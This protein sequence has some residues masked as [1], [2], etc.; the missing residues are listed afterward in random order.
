MKNYG[1]ENIA[2]SQI[3]S[4]GKK[5]RS[6]MAKDDAEK[7]AVLTHTEIQRL[8]IREEMEGVVYIGGNWRRVRRI[9][10]RKLVH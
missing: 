6:D 3:V 5:I 8:A 1:F 7:A 9:A 2:P 4:T 10:L